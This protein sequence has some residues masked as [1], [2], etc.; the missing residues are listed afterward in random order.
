MS[1]NAWSHIFNTS[2]YYL[3]QTTCPAT[4]VY[5]SLEI[6]NGENNSL[7]LKI[8]LWMF[9]DKHEA[10]RTVPTYSEVQ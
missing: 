4:P 1:E 2:H 8:L 7:C 6:K 10:L 5:V 3:G 9:Q